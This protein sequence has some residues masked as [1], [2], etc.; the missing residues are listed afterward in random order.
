MD[1][2]SYAKDVAAV[3]WAPSECGM[4]P[5][6]VLGFR[7][8]CREHHSNSGTSLALRDGIHIHLLGHK[9]A[10]LNTRSPR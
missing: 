8:R 4:R 10:Y 7:H 6:W 2:V 9:Y 1:S 3:R 5:A